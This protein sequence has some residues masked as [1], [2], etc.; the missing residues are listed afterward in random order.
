MDV[1]INLIVIIILQCIPLSNNYVVHFKY[2]QFCLSIIP[3]KAG[4]N[5]GNA[6]ESCF[7]NL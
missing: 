4:E 1:L 2:I 7:K 5:K 3:R 6:K